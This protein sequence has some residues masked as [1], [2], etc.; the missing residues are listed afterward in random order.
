MKIF[1]PSSTLRLYVL[2]PAFNS[3]QMKT[4]R[5]FISAKRNWEETLSQEQYLS[6]PWKECSLS[7]EYAQ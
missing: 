5:A 1:V 4:L 2:D 7:L 3:S 6:P